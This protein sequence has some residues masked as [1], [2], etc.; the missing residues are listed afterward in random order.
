MYRYVQPFEKDAWVPIRSEELEARL[1][2]LNAKRVTI[3]EVSELVEDG[4]DKRSYS[5]RGPLY[6]DIDCK[7]DLKLAIESGRTLAH[8]LADLGV[9]KQGIRVYAS[10]S[11]GVHIT[12]DQKYFSSGR[13]LKG[14]PLVYKAMAK[15]LF[16]PGMDMGVYSCGR[17]NA[18][19]VANVKRD[20]GHY[21]VPLMLEE[22]DELTVEQ[23]RELT[24][25]PRNLS[26]MEPVPCRVAA[27]ELLFDTARKEINSAPAQ[28]IIV[29]S[30]ESLEGLAS[31]VPP[32][33]QAIC[34]WKGVRSERNLNQVSLQLAV[35]I[36]RTGVSDV[37]A[38]G[39]ISR[40][41]ESARSSK[42]E[43]LRQKYDHIRGQ[44][45]YMAHTPDYRFSCPSMRSLLE[46][47]PCKGCAIEESPESANSPSALLGLVER[48][49]GMFMSGVKNDRMLSNFTMV[50]TDHYIDIPLSGGT[51]RRVGTRIELRDGGEMVATVVFSESSWLSRS[52]FMRDTTEGHGVLMFFGTDNDVQAIKGHV[53]NKERSMGEIYRVHT[54][55]T[56]IEMI[57]ATEVFTYVEPDM[58]INS[59]KIQGTHELAA[60][61]VGRPYFSQ[62]NI[63]STEDAD[64]DQAL[65]NLLNINQPL[66]V[67]LIMGWFAACH[68]KTHLMNLYSQF[69]ILSVW[70]SAGSGK[71]VTV[72]LMSWINGTDYTMRDTPVNVSNITPYAILDYSSSTTTVPRILEEYNKSKMRANNWKAVGEMLKASWNGE[73]VLRGTISDSKKESTRTGA[74]V[75]KIPITSP[76]VVVSEQELEMPALQERS[77][78]VKLTKERR[79]GRK[80]FLKEASKGRMKLRSVGKALMAKSLQMSIKDVEALFEE[81]ESFVSDELDD[82]PRYSYQICLLGVNF[83]LKVVSED[84]KLQKSAAQLTDMLDEMKAYF[85]DLGETVTEMNARSEV[86]SV[87]EDMNVMAGLSN[88]GDIA[89]LSKGVHYIVADDGNTLVIDPMLTHALYKKFV[90]AT[91]S[92]PVVIESAKQFLSLIVGEPYY[93]S[94]RPVAGMGGGRPMV[95]LNRDRM[96]SKGVDTSNFD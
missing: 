33:V 84:L 13:P 80:E 40:L 92:Q 77:I 14:L 24:S 76:L 10:G 5:Y 67:G 44:V 64:A 63:C 58:S 49:E 43:T 72:A 30:K 71:S 45:A 16:V 60:D 37:V 48:D 55:G 75:T 8:K 20:D 56:H 91:S 57:G 6:F 74:K 83:L 28:T 2:D 59:N 46:R 69:P 36:A 61:M 21:R 86:D 95:R 47:S 79:K 26:V 50:P 38:D 32:C 4:R 42:Y 70:G 27:L 90:R 3:L 93:E 88:S 35:Y 17:G 94:Q 34:D 1:K 39:L 18:F 96:R 11:K 7:T 62:C 52:A 31:E 89:W 19:R 54:C 15:D 22:L 9:P 51:G 12:V 87:M 78:R 81:T 66:E 82:R 73:T 25:K 29:S 23:Y 41:A 53:L 85:S 65:Y 68:L